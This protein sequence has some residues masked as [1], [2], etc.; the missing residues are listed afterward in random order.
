[1]NN[2][3]KNSSPLSEKA[4]RMPLMFVGHGSPMNAIENNIYTKTWSELGR[5]LPAPKAILSISAHWLT[6]GSYVTSM[7]LPPTIHDF[8]G[9]PKELYTQTYP[10]PGSPVFA[11]KT[12][13]MVI[14]PQIISDLKWGLDHGTWSVLLPMFPLANIPVFQLSIDYSKPPE[15]HFKLAKQLSFLRDEGV[16]IMGSGNMVHNLGMLNFE[17]KTYDWALEFDQKITTLLETEDFQSIINFMDFGSLTKI[18][19]PTI[20]HFL[21]LIYVIG[22]RQK[23]DKLEFFNEGFDLGSISMRSLIYS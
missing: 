9:F 8:G 12:Q 3:L 15:Y 10:A 20:D 7:E 5:V 14:F 2:L 19:H 23:S 18:S 16:L 6:T 11:E 21:P 22:I 17:S 13:K 1:M 4:E